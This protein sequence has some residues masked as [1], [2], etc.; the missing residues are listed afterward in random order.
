VS[1]LTV[2]LT[3]GMSAHGF[4]SRIRNLRDFGS[5]VLF[6]AVGV[7]AIFLSRNYPL[8]STFKMGPG[9]FPT[10]LG[11]LLV[12][13]GLLAIARSLIRSGAALEAIAWRRLAVILG[14][15][16]VF[17]LLMRGAGLVPAIVALVVIATQASQHTHWKTTLGLALGLSVFSVVVFVKL[18]GL[19]IAL[20][21]PWLGG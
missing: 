3:F 12:V 18:L 4:L 21:G 11:T 15:V 16:L 10:A 19:P 8:G 1:P 14:G 9:Y 7:A 13:V 17:G 20:I 6:V 5:G 2:P